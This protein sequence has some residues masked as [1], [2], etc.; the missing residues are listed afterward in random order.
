MTVEETNVGIRHSQ[1]VAGRRKPSAQATSGRARMGWP[2]KDPR[3]YQPKAQREAIARH[4]LP[5]KLALT[6]QRAASLAHV[7][8]G[9]TVDGREQTWSFGVAVN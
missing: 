6:P 5:A 9:V 4:G 3:D 1:Q 2:S 7:S 8:V